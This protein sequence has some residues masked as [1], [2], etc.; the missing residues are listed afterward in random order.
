[1]AL[2]SPEQ[3]ADKGEQIYKAR[4]QQEYE[5]QH[6]G[7]FVAIEIDSGEAFLADTPEEA[8]EAAQRARDRGLFHLIKVG[9][10]GLYRVSYT[11]ARRD[12][13]V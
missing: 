6:L 11:N 12:W 9:A 2:S 10:P 5:Q 13:L 4:Y 7:K 8:I 3:I 1:M